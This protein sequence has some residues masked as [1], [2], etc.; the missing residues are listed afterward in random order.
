MDQYTWADPPSRTAFPVAAPGYPFIYAAAFATIIFALVGWGI[1]AVVGMI[2][3]VC[4]CLFFR[5]PDRVTPVSETAL[6]SPADGRVVFVGKTASNPYIDG[7]CIKVGIFMSVFNVHVNRVPFTGKI[8]AI[9]YYPGTFIPADKDAASLKNERNAVIM[10]TSDGRTIGFV[11]VAGLIARRIISWV[12]VGDHVPAGSRFGMICFGSRVD[13]YLPVE[14]EV[15]VR[16]GDRVAAGS[17]VIGHLG[18]PVN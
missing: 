17:S 12:N 10:T 6:I 4:I 18:A 7:P 13:L 11:Q 14:S 9:Q 3:T 1:A 16:V 5:D 8:S 2:A 15:S